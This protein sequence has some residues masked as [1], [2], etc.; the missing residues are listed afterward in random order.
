MLYVAAQT[1]ARASALAALEAVRRGRSA[2]RDSLAFEA[3]AIDLLGQAIERTPAD[4][5]PEFWREVVA[6]DDAMRPLLRNPQVVKRLKP[7]VLSAR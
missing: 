5:R 3:R 7:V 2:S 1:Y 6:R 4:E